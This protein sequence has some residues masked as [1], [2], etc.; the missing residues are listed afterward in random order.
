MGRAAKLN[1][2]TLIAQALEDRFGISGLW[3]ARAV[4][5]MIF[6]IPRADGDEP[7][8]PGLIQKAIAAG[9]RV[10]I[11]GFGSF[12]GRMIVAQTKRVPQEDGSV[13]EVDVPEHP[14]PTFHASERFKTFVRDR[15]LDPAEPGA[16]GD[17]DRVLV[18]AEVP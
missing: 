3:G 11:R 16:G 5:D 7:A 2:R 6:G 17:G 15:Y 18:H 13:Q 8:D 10:S 1:G 14:V 12:D 4:V 9:S